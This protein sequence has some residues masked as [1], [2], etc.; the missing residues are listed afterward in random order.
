MVSERRQYYVWSGSHPDESV[1]LV[2]PNILDFADPPP[3]NL[4][5]SGQA[6]SSPPGSPVSAWDSIGGF[7]SAS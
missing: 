7:L 2:A 6:L 4:V 5:W 1:L 3:G